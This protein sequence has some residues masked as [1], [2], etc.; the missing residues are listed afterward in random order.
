MIEIDLLSQTSYRLSR[1]QR[2]K[3]KEMKIEIEK[4]HSQEDGGRYY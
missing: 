1:I 4:R 2:T 3:P